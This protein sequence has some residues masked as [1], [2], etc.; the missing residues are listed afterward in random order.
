[1]KAQEKG[2]HVT[3]YALADGRTMQI[4]TQYTDFLEGGQ[5]YH[6]RLDC[7]RIYGVTGREAQV[8]F[9]HLSGLVPLPAFLEDIQ[10][11]TVTEKES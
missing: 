1:M 5:C 6:R 9:D 3:H 2:K 7:R 4:I 8:V 10:K 11:V